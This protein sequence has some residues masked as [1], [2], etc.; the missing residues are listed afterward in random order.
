MRVNQSGALARAISQALSWGEVVP[1]YKQFAQDNRVQ[2]L[3]VVFWASQATSG[4]LGDGT[5]S[6]N[7]LL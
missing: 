4:L 2:R 7:S 1:P 3:T 6:T 5:L